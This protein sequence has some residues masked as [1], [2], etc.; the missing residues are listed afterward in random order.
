MA[1]RSIG[2]TSSVTRE[3]GSQMA[4]VD[5][6]VNRKTAFSSNSN[7]GRNTTKGGNATKGNA[8]S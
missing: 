8:K 1:R 4:T 5:S 6:R 7:R 3:R 2:H